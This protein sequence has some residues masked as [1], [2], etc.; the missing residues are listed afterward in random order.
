MFLDMIV[1]RLGADA[2]PTPQALAAIAALQKTAG[3]VT[4]R[5]RQ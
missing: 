1:L 3:S 5:A 4:A 2:R